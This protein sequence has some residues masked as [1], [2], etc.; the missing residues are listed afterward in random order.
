LTKQASGVPSALLIGG[1]LTLLVSMNPV[2]TDSLAPGVPALRD[3]F[4]VS[5]SNANLVFSVY[6]FAFGFMQLVYGPIADRFGRRP[7][8]LVAIGLYCVATLMA[9][10]APTFETLLIARAL[11]GAS[12]S[13]APALARAVIRDLYGVEGSRRV[14]SYV[15]SAFGIMAITAPA[16]GGVLVAWQGWQASFYF[17]LVYGIFTMSAVF[18]LLK[19]SRPDDAPTT[20]S[21]STTFAVYVRLTPTPIF[22]L[23]CVSNMLMY[24]AMFVWL[25]GSMLVI[26]DGYG[27]APELA[28][29]FFACG[30]AGFMLGAGVAG[31]LGARLHAP[32]LIMLGSLTGIFAAAIILTLALFEIRSGLAVALPA[33]IWMFGHGL[34]YPQSM[35]AAVAPFPQTAGAASSLIG[36]YQTCAGAIAAFIMGSIHDGSAVPLGGLML[37]L[38]IL[39]LLAYAPFYRRVLRQ[40]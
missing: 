40:Q 33:F 17:C 38:S 18:I 34:H 24:A 27:V 16:I 29:L 15:M 5:T 20:L 32:S 39:A 10:V 30:S 4:G 1:V 8:L 11:Q 21:L 35:A 23:N 14:M 9:A 36:F 12:A 25:S 13:A 28:G 6:V 26:I 22:A 37:G 31:R 2:S 7:V 19:E 3:Y